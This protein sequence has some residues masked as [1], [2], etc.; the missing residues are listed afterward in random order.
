LS[1][2]RKQ[3]SGELDVGLHLLHREIWV[4]SGVSE[5]MHIDNVLGDMEIIFI[6]LLVKDNKEDIESGHDW[7]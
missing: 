5:S 7:W 6:I 3:G 2:L 1:E 4:E